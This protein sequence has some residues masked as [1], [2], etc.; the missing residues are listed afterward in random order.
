MSY[1]YTLSVQYT[2][3]FL[4]LEVILLP[5]PKTTFNKVN[6]KLNEERVLIRWRRLSKMLKGHGEYGRR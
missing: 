4:L 5:S 2:S 3:L 1:Q 6:K